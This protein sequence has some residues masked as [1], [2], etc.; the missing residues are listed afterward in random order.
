VK[1]ELSDLPGHAKLGTTLV[2]RVLDV[3]KPIIVNPAYRHRN[4]IPVPEPG[5][6]LYRYDTKGQK[7][8]VRVPLNGQRMGEQLRNLLKSPDIQTEYDLTASQHEVYNANN[9]GEDVD[10]K[11]HTKDIQKRQ[12]RQ[13]R[14]PAA[15][16]NSKSTGRKSSLQTT[17]PSR[18]HTKT[19]KR[20]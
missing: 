20:P 14:A 10:I 9:A 7:V 1:Y 13:D 6:L 17:P 18:I 15:S 11:V 4:F 12:D 5:A 3:I 19:T 2:I 16:K 8:I